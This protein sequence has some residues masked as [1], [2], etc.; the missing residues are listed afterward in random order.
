MS[1]K[2]LAL[3]LF[4]FATVASAQTPIQSLSEYLGDN[5][6]G[7]ERKDLARWI[8]LAISVHPENRPFASQAARDATD[9]MDKAVAAIFTR[10]LTQSCVT[11]ARAATKEGGAAAIKAGFEALGR[12]A[13]Q[14]LMSDKEVAG[15]MTAFEK[16]FD[17]KKLN[18]A[19]GN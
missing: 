6:S 12:L 8:F 2:V 5:T 3:I 10:L 16:H 7:R 19:L 14:E 9:V 13:M 4:A 1:T 15:R 18:S 11:Q 17:R